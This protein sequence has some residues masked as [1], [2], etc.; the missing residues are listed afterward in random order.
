VELAHKEAQ[1]RNERDRLRKDSEGLESRAAALRARSEKL[2]GELVQVR[3]RMESSRAARAGL[4]IEISGL[5]QAKRDEEAVQ[6]RLREERAQVERELLQLREGK[7]HRVA[8]RETLRDLEESYEGLETGAKALLRER[9][10]GVLG[11]VADFLDVAPEHVAAVEAALGERAGAVVCVT[12]ADAERA[13]ALVRE[14]GWGRTL[15]LSLEE[16]RNGHFDPSELAVVPGILGRAHERAQ[17]EERFRP[18]A[19][20]LLGH[21]L[22]V[23]DPVTAREARR[24]GLAAALVTPEGERFDFPGLVTTGS[25]A[26]QGLLSRKAE[27]RRL[28]DEI[29][30]Y[31]ELITQREGR[32][33]ETEIQIDE[34]AH[35]LEQVRQQVYEKTVAMSDVDKEA[36]QLEGREQAYAVE[37]EALGE[38]LEAVGRQSKAVEDRGAALDSLLAQLEWLKAQVTQ[39]LATLAETLARYERGRAELQEGLQRAQMDRTRANEQMLSARKHLEMLEGMRAEAGRAV[40]RLAERRTETAGRLDV[41]AGEVRRTEAERE[42]LGRTVAGARER[43]AE[44]GRQAEALAA[45]SESAREAKT[46]IEARVGPCEAEIGG[47]RVE[48]G[49]QQTK[50]EALVQRAREEEIDLS[51]AAAAAPPEEGTDWEAVAHEAEELRISIQRFGSV[52]AVALDQLQELEEREK[53]ML[54]QKEDLDQSKGQLE[55]LIRELNLQSRE[56]FD[57]TIDLVRE[58]FNVIFRKVFGGGK[59]D[60][61]V[62]QA[63][64]VDPMEQGLEITARP[65]G[66]QDTSISL[67]SGG[68][69]S[70]TAIALVMALFKANPGPFC[71]LDEADAALDEKNVERY[72]GLIREF[73]ADTQ[74]I[75]ITHNKRTMAVTDVLYGVTMEQQGVSKKVS[76]NLAG[77]QGLDVLKA[78]GAPAVPQAAPAAS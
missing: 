22:V 36:A 2:D 66:K 35:R 58:Q 28:Q 65:P 19:D 71:L 38:E 25:K 15:L 55:D 47:L 30:R 43:A 62:E 46:G 59:A 67:L 29:G 72:A 11:A 53:F 45:E 69:R 5:M 8:R 44:A 39:E 23:Q 9:P 4:E 17:V 40:E 77:D 70:L 52:N 57:K 12:A 13:A 73:A 60:I 26:L 61:I 74:F 63:E 6:A 37:C 10:E 34:A 18:M 1:Y 20:A 14:R 68:E 78:K 54:G 3:S 27:L 64:G 56:L 76:V 33:A 31:L 42:E 21:T 32:Q 24:A 41:A 49:Q 48:E 51:A 7:D 75:V 16:C 50:L